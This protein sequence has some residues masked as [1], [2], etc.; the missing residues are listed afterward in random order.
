LHPADLKLLSEEITEIQR[1]TLDLTGPVY[2]A[3]LL[4][5]IEQEKL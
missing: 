1:G 5:V 4:L 3:D 2:E